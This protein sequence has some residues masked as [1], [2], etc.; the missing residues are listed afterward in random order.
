MPRPQ[1]FNKYAE[2]GNYHWKQTYSGG[3]MRFSPLAHARYDIVLH[4]IGREL[5][6]ASSLGLDVGCGDGVMLYKIRL[7]GGTAI[8]LDSD[9]I[10]LRIAKESYRRLIKQEPMLLQASCYEIPLRDECVDF[11]TAIELIE[12]LDDP[13]IFLEEVVRVLV[14]SGVFCL[15]TPN[16]LAAQGPRDVYHVQEYTPEELQNMLAPFF[17]QVRILGQFPYDLVRLYRNATGIRL[18]D[19]LVRFVFKVLLL[20]HLNPFVHTITLSPDG[21]W[22]TLVAICKKG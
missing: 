8:G 16:R 14:P 18:I 4:L 19:K 17:S 3:W 10:G 5:H 20:L 15:T 22:D 13:R 6:L 1:L 2:L 7:R 21:H 9:G 12:H 11:V